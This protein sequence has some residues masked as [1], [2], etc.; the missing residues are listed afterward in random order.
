MLYDYEGNPIGG[1]SRLTGKK[2]L[3]IGDSFIKGHTLS[4]SQTWVHKLA[5][6]NGMTSYNYGINGASIAYD[7]GHTTYTSVSEALPS[8]LS[9]VSSTDYV[10]LLG[11]H[12]D[13]NPDLHGGTAIPIGNNTDTVNTTFKGALNIIITD[14]LGAYPTAKMLFLSPFNRR[15]IEKPYEEAMKEI[16]GLYSQ[17]FFDCYDR[18]GITFDVAE[19]AAVYELNGSLH[20]NEAGQERF[21]YVVESLLNML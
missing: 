1:E 4:D 6:R 16:T 10:V 9:A 17:R 2:I 18:S 19:V 20:L 7:A 15:G 8:I 13:A 11:G 14:L 3:A 5:Q 21:S 12:N